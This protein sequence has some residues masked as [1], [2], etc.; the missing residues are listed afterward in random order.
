MTQSLSLSG[1]LV[2]DG[3][4]RQIAPL[5]SDRFREWSGAAHVYQR[6]C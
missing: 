2:V 3:S 5:L 6:V 4:D 1:L